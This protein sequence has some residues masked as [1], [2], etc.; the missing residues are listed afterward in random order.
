[1]STPRRAVR[2]AGALAAAAL[3]LL[4]ANVFAPLEALQIGS[5]LLLGLGLVATWLGVLAWRVPVLDRRRL[6]ALGVLWLVGVALSAVLVVLAT[7]PDRSSLW[8]YTVEWLALALSL[9]VGAL[10]LRA[11]LRVRTSP[12]SGRLLSLASPFAILALIVL[13]ALF[14]T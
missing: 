2:A 12:L 9:A 13:L 10:F 6:A 11:L 7:D 14:K 4:A 5:L 1:M 8:R 3:T